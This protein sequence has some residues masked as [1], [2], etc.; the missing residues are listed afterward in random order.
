MEPYER[1]KVLR[2]NT[3]RMTQE[4]FARQINISRSNLGN[5]ET[6][7]IGL[8]DRVIADV[9]RSFLVRREWIESGEGRVF[10]DESTLLEMEIRRI[11][12][13]LN[14]ENRKYVAGFMRYL[15]MCQER[16]EPAYGTAYGAHTTAADKK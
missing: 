2:K 8:T 15:L 1:I 5:I 10:E 4:D 7:K 12:E 6:G 11:S 3:L 16:N 13:Q 9:C 14:E